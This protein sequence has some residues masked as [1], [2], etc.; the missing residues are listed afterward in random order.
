MRADTGLHADQVSIGAPSD[1]ARED[2][3]ARD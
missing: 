2:K 1:E 3:S